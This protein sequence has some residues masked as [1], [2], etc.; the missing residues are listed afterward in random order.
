MN[1][2]NSR[3]S[4]LPGR[5][6]HEQYHKKFRAQL[7]RECMGMVLTRTMKDCEG[8]TSIRTRLLRGRVEALHAITQKALRKIE[9]G[10]PMNN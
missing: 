7:K 3:Y 5:V 10:F 6:L 8:T 4:A 1:S 2:G 9:C